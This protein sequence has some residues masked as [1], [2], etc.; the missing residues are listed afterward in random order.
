MRYIL[1]APLIFTLFSCSNSDNLNQQNNEITEDIDIPVS[2]VDYNSL[3][4]WVF[5]PD[6]TSIL[7]NY[8]LDIEVIDQNLQVEQIIPITN[9]SSTNT[10]I[11]VFW[12]H[13]T[14]ITDNS[15]AGNVEISDQP[16]VLISLTI[17]AQGGLLSKYGRMYAPRYRQSTGLVYLDEN[18][19]KEVQANYIATSYSDVKTAFL[20]YLNNHNNGNKII[21]AGHSQGSYLIAMLLRDLFDNDSLLRS[22]LLTAS[23]GGMGYVYAK[24]NLYRGG[25]WENIP[26]CTTTDQ[27]GCIHNWASFDEQQNIIDINYSLPMFNPYLLNSGLVYRKFDMNEDWFAQ[28]FSYYGTNT[29]ALKNYITPNTSYNLGNGANFIAFNGLYDV[30]QKREG[31]LKVALSLQHNSILNDLRPDELGIEQ[32]NVNYSNWGYHTKDYHI[33]LW[34][35]MS[36]IDE[37]INGCN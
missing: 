15:F 11:D 6:K 32:N 20:N 29:V 17:I 36:Q 34:A 26:L 21:L 18:I 4:N 23:L 24:E 33:Y 31:P 16:G 35:L 7:T 12:V 10:G 14:Q 37:K 25:W 5:H 19:D 28:D 1:L 8:N 22:K 2:T 13:P 9:N 27:C 30:R 3:N